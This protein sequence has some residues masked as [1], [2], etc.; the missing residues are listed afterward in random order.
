MS[1]GDLLLSTKLAPPRRTRHTLARP[2][3][4][5]RL[6]EALD[7]RLTVV[8]AGTGYGKTTALAALAAELPQV[9]WYSAGEED[10]DPHQFLAYLAAAFRLHL[11]ALPDA[12]LAA[13][14]EAGAGRTATWRRATDALINSLVQSLHGP[15]LLIVDDYHFVGGSPEIDA[16]TQR[17]VT[18]LPADLH[19]I[20]A[21]RQALTWPELVRWRATGEALEIDYRALAFS[22]AEIEALFRTTYARPLTPAELAALADRT[23]GWPIAL[24]LVWQRLRDSAERGVADVLARHPV[25][26]GAL[27]SYLADAVLARQPPHLAAFL[28]ETA[29]LRELTP[30]ACDAVRQSEALLIRPSSFVAA[31]EMLRQL[32]ELDLFVVRLGAGHYRYHHLFHDFL[33]EQLAADP[34]HLRANH[35][36]AARFFQ[37]RGDEEE[38]IYHW[39]AARELALAAAAIERAGEAMLQAGRLDTVA[40]WLQAL[41]ETIL[42]AHPRLQAYMGDVE[43]LRSR[44]DDA[45]A[46]YAQ[47]EQTWRARGDLAGLSRALRGR[48]RIYLDTV[49]PTEAEGLLQEALRLLDDTVDHEARAR[50]LELMAENKL[51]LGDPAAAE[52]LR[53][54]AG[55]LREGAAGEDALSVRVK[56]R[57]GRLDA[58]QRILETWAA[59]ERAEAARGQMHPPRAHRETMLLLALIHSFRGEAEQAAR[60]AE[61]GVVLGERLQS[62]FVTAV[63]YTRLGH[64]WQL[65]YGQGWPPAGRPALAEAIRCYQSA[66]ALGD[67]LAVRRTRA[68]ALW[69]LTRAYGFFGD[70]ESAR[71]AAAEG[72]EI[73]GGA[74]DQWMGALIELALGAGYVL[75]GQHAVAIELLDRQL[76]AFRDCGDSFG[77]AAARL[78][79]SLA[80]EAT[81]QAERFASCVE[82]ALAL[83]ETHGYDFLWSAPTLLGPPDPARL[84]PMLLEARSRRRRLAY[85]ARLLAAAGHS[86][87]QL[88][89]GYR[90]RFQMLGAFRAW[91]GLDEIEPREWQR[92]KARQLVQLLLTTRGRWLQRDELLEH[93]WPELAPDAAGRSFKVALNALY[94]AIE[95]DRAPDAPS[96]YVAREGSA[97]RLRPEADLWLDAGEFEQACEAGLRLIEGGATKP[98]LGHLQ[99][100]LDLYAGDYLPDA[101]AEDWAVAERE[102]LLSLYLRAADALGGALVAHG[103]ADEAVEIC[104]RILA[105]D[106]CWER[107]Y[108]M[109]MQAYARQGNRPQ[110][111]RAYQRCVQV[112]DSELGVD[113]SPSTRALYEQLARVRE[114]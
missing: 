82:D 92:D 100:A 28:Y 19:V 88:H 42:A 26:L 77:G 93:L 38:A 34:E 90:L 69:G 106:P 27:F 79:L 45:L 70:L 15:S 53:H 80:Y 31:S 71:Q 103:R 11:P 98:A 23:E 94:K 55:D 50:L 4:V 41:P 104:Q 64:A 109:M 60:L 48:A 65:R 105:R 63:A 43:R 58:A 95:P 83:C 84:V 108:R 33:R 44:F 36:R 113:P 62:P 89:P 114:A 39:L 96:A 73:A 9:F 6:H 85:A 66:I 21:T 17:F 8:Q 12:P 56:L 37:D 110:A 47:A 87:L 2:E 35:G 49:R 72:I 32:H 16:L 68:E 111:L 22:P 52:A 97:Y 67:R 81:G 91:R 86:E 74:G 7:H 57:T 46:W 14:R 99:H 13:L 54:A 40:G 78:W 107:A 61:H 59:A 24:Q 18:Y 25:S 75:H 30:D 10:A 3:L 1:Y 29:V 76:H 101:P 102:R 20:L 5:A 51:N 112:L